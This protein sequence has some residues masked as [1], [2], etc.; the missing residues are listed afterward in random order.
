[1]LKEDAVHRGLTAEVAGQLFLDPQRFST[2]IDEALLEPRTL[3][4]F[5]GG[6]TLLRIVHED[7]LQQIKE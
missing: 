2:V 4:G 5:F 3:Q 7:T 6:D 1:M